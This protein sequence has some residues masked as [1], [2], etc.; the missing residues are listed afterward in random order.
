[1]LHILLTVL[2]TV[3]TVLLVLLA[4]AALLILAVLFMPVCYRGHVEKRE[5]VLK[6]GL[7][8]SWMFRLVYVRVRYEEKQPDAEIYLL[9]IPVLRIR[10]Y[11]AEKKK[12]ENARRKPVHGPHRKPS[13]PPG[14]RPAGNRRAGGGAAAELPKVNVVLQAEETAEKKKE[15]GILRFFRKAAEIPGKIR[16]VFRKVRFT[17]GSFCAKIKEWHRFLTSR[18]FR[19]AWEAVKLHGK[20]ILRHIL[21]KKVR[22]YVRFGFDD[23]AST[24][25]LTGVAGMFLPMIPEGLHIVPDFRGKCLEADVT[26]GGRIVVFVLLRHGLAI[27]R[28]KYVQRVIKKFQHK[29]A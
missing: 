15:S 7:R 4:I 14:G 26:A 16:D 11:L 13:V 22:G 5:D 23:P 9:G 21:P 1:M 19:R 8:V 12:K 29:E 28:N 2:S 24:G 18:T 25:Q 17:I 6:A 10:K 20:K 3:G 27:Y